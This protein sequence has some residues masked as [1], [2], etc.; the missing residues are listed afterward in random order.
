MNAN[1]LNMWLASLLGDPMSE[2]K[3]DIGP[4]NYG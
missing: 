1:L 2:T 4:S 3:K